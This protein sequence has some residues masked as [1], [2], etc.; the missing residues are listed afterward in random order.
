MWNI[1][2]FIGYRWWR[3]RGSAHYVCYV[4]SG[5]IRKYLHT[6]GLKWW[7]RNYRAVQIL[8][9]MGGSSADVQQQCCLQDLKETQQ[10]MYILYSLRYRLRFDTA[11][12]LPVA[13]TTPDVCPIF[14]GFCG[15]RALGNIEEPC[16]YI[17]ALFPAVH[18]KIFQ[19]WSVHRLLHNSSKVHSYR[20]KYCVMKG[21]RVLLHPNVHSIITEWC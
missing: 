7:L 15:C 6:S 14:M 9:E 17:H 20:W 21:F 11:S 4:H 13:L 19:Q 12:V 10:D 16:T 18:S 3:S 1:S 5:Q 2:D 8:G